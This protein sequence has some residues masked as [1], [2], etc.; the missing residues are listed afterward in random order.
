MRVIQSFC[1]TL[2]LCWQ[3]WG[4]L[5]A[6]DG[7]NLGP[8]AVLTHQIEAIE[9]ETWQL[10]ATGEMEPLGRTWY[11]YDLRG[12]L[13]STQTFD[14][15]GTERVSF[16]TD[17][18][19]DDQRTFRSISSPTVSSTVHWALTYDEGHRLIAEQDDVL[20]LLRR[21][22][23]DEQG[24]VKAILT[25]YD[26][27]SDPFSVERFSYDPAGRVRLYQHRS[28]LMVKT[29]RTCYDAAGRRIETC[30]QTRYQV[31][32]EADKQRCLRY[33]YDEQGR[34][35]RIDTYGA[36]GEPLWRMTL[37][38]DAQG[39]LAARQVGAHRLVYLRDKAGL[40]SEQL[41][42]LGDR[43]VA[44]QIYRYQRQNTTPIATR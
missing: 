34:L 33:R 17:F 12:H 29:T 6:Q 19:F 18:D 22:R 30:R 27:E 35:S 25:S 14:V 21:Y 3:A 44:R 8:Q 10:A 40:I 5:S 36:E 42:Y 26:A 16:E 9:V 24:R 1:C 31:P 41:R 2:L 37:S 11:R 32:G 39:Q 28:E 38:Y 7:L 13:V 23:Y 15:S 4:A 20:G 43:L